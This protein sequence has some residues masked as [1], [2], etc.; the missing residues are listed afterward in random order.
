MFGAS[1]P[2]PSSLVPGETLLELRSCHSLLAIDEQTETLD[3]VTCCPT[4]LGIYSVAPRVKIDADSWETA[5]PSVLRVAGGTFSIAEQ[6]F[7][8]KDLLRYHG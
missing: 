2:F 1:S 4:L 7:Y 6:N 8:R 3:K 5:T